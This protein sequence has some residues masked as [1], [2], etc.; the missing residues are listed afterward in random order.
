M[1]AKV[2]NPEQ[3][4][5]Q[6]AVDLRRANKKE[7]FPRGGRPWRLT[8][9]SWRR[10]STLNRSTTNLTRWTSMDSKTSLISRYRRLNRT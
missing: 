2:D 9:L 3:K 10:W 7:K 5:E 6:M 4:R 1:T 8:K